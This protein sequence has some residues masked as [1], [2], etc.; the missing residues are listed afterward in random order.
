ME[1]PSDDA[2]RFLVSRYAHLLAEHG[3]VFEGVELVTPTGEHFP[4]A[5]AKDPES[6]G[7]LLRRMMSYAPL[8]EDLVVHL[9]FVEPEAEAEG[10]SCSSGACGTG[11]ASSARIDGVEESR[12][13][14]RA[15]VNVTDVGHPVTLTTSLARSV[16][17]IVLAEAEEE[18]ERATVGAMSEIAA[19]ATGLGVLLLAGSH[20]YRKGC[21]GASVQQHTTLS[22]SELAVLTALFCAVNDV[23]PRVVRAHLATTQAEAF[24][25][26]VAWVDTND[27]LVKALRTTPETLV[28]GLFSMERTRGFLSRLFKKKADDM[29]LGVAVSKP[30]RVRTPD[31][32]RRLAEARALVDEALSESSAGE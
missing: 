20:V 22:V 26:A 5:F 28:G 1:L 21:S 8:D 32:E 16:G 30:A 15:F 18:I 6:V 19:A 10:K 25:D 23:K 24:D 9:A 27:H 13:S 31:E 17:A 7:H 11:G 14:Y 29:P 4:D 12:G 2:L 3:E